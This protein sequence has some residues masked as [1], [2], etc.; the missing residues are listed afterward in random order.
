ML[1]VAAA[2]STRVRCALSRPLLIPDTDP[3]HWLSNIKTIDG[4]CAAVRLYHVRAE[5]ARDLNALQSLCEAG[6]LV[7]ARR[8]VTYFDLNSQDARILHNYA[9]FMSCFN[10]HL[11][12]AQWLVARF[13]LT[14]ED[15]RSGHNHA[16]HWACRNG[17]LAVAQWLVEHFDMVDTDATKH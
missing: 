17:H 9:L 8:L 16:L 4:F 14:L 2:R 3:L 6:M 15:A 10:G 11:A 12:T 13:G 1:F 5:D 7:L